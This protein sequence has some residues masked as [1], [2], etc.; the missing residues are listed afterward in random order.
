MKLGQK[1][2][3]RARRLAEE[4]VELAVRHRQANAV[5]EIFK[6]ELERAVGLEVDQIVENYRGVTRLPIGSEPHQL[7]FA[8]CDAPHLERPGLIH[9]RPAVR[10]GPVHDQ[11]VAFPVAHSPTPSRVSTAADE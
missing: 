7:V 4:P 2:I 11:R 10:I 5:V 8:R 9:P 3:R 6:V 1:L